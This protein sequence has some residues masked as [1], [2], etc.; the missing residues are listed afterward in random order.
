[1]KKP[2]LLW[3]IISLI[4]LSCLADIVTFLYGG[5]FAFEV[6]PIFIFLLSY[7][8]VLVTLIAVISYKLLVNAAIIWLLISYKPEK[9][10]IFAFLLIVS[11]LVAIGLQLF[12]SYQN[13]SV[14]HA[15]DN[16]PEGVVPTPLTTS[17]SYSLFGSA[18]FIYGLF[19]LF[20]A[21]SFW[22]YEK[23]FTMH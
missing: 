8:S 11:T 5:N 4:G 16:P 12:G 1:M 10:H 9:S 13:L 23:L 3:I 15:I 2:I 7:C 6:N 22:V 21:V 14:H 18:F 19:V 17:Q 20:E